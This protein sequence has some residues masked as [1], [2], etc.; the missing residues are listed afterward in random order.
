MKKLRCL[1][2]DDKPLAIDIL[3]DYIAKTS[4]LEFV[5]ATTNPI[6]ALERV[7][8]NQI[9]LVFLDIQMPELNGM[10]FIKIAGPGCKVILTTA[11]SKYAL[12]GY[13][14]DV[15]DYLLK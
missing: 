1:V 8:Q 6:G 3:A 10:Q 7:R 9:D 12:E 14:H 4:F 11:Y 5:A 13:E 15:V 2:V